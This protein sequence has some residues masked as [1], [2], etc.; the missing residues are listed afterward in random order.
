M[1][2]SPATVSPPSGD[3]RWKLVEGTIRR[4]RC[5][6]SAL[7]EVLHAVQ[8]AFGYIDEQALGYVARVLKLPAGK[9][10]GVA[11]FHP[12]FNLKPQGEH[13]CVICTGTACYIKGAGHLLKKVQEATELRPGE[14]SK[15]HR[16]SLEAARC[17][18]SCG[19]GPVVLLDGEFSGQLGPGELEHRLRGWTGHEA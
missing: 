2:R 14:T 15:D 10:Y 1:Q 5:Q 18:G 7:L 9:V 17:L 19:M 8:E 16:L 4:H 13:S 11:T 3:R 6:P 12:L